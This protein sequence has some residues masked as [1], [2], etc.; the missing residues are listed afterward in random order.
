MDPAALI[1]PG[2]RLA[3]LATRLELTVESATDAPED[4]WR[5]LVRTHDRVVLGA[6]VD[7]GATRWR[8]A[9]G[10]TRSGGRLNVLTNA[11]PL[12]PSRA[13]RGHGL[14]LRWPATAGDPFDPSLVVVDV[15]NEGN[16]RWHPSGDS[17]HTVGV[18]ARKGEATTAGT[19]ALI[20]GSSPA[21]ALDPGEYARVHVHIQPGQ[22]QD[23]QPGEHEVH[24]LLV[25]LG[26][27]TAE[28]LRIM[29]SD[30]EIEANRPAQR[31]SPP[32]EASQQ[33]ALRSRLELLRTLG[34]VRRRLH[35]VTDIIMDSPSRDAARARIEALLECTA[36]A[37]D[38][39][40]ALSLQRLV[41]AEQDRIVDEI[42]ELER[43]LESAGEPPL[44]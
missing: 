11:M 37:A 13:K 27:R 3:E 29:L 15:T 17:F 21:F 26:V 34:S 6:P 31:T 33:Q 20:G 43:E 41:H 38:A 9:I 1:E 30:A 44:S 36:E 23:L 14:A 35:E 18:I 5:V 42:R 12:R 25:D 40:L 32:G 7:D 10:E 16:E 28:P 24:A 19:L 22:W 39:V 2:E 4:G 8:V